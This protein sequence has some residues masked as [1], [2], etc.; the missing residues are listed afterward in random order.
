MSGLFC[1][2]SFSFFFFFSLPPSP[3]SS[4]LSTKVWLYTPPHGPAARPWPQPGPSRR[5]FRSTADP[6]CGRSA[7]S[8]AGRSTAPCP[9]HAQPPGCSNALFAF[10]PALLN[11]SAE[12]ERNRDSI[13]T[14]IRF[15]FLPFDLIFF[16]FLTQFQCASQSRQPSSS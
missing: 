15:F 4:D 6:R 8:P 14:Q 13:C 1:F 9:S 2:V 7:P 11:E 10:R 3:D 12:R 5:P 16:S